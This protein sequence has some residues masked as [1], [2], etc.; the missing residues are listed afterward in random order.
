MEG[1]ED[2]L[3]LTYFGFFILYLISYQ[4]VL[5]DLEQFRIIFLIGPLD[6]CYS[7]QPYYG[8]VFH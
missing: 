7:L 8:I 5:F 3:F 6:A 4:W 1:V 2:A